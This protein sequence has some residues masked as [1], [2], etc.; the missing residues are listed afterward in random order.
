MTLQKKS[1]KPSPICR[2]C[3]ITIFLYTLSFSITTHAELKIDS[4]YPTLGQMGQNLE[5]EIKG[6]GFDENTRVSMF[7]DSSNERMLVGSVDT[8][9]IDQTNDVFVSGSYAY[10]VGYP[11]MFRVIDVSNSSNPEIIGSVD[12]NGHGYGVFVSGSYA[13]VACSPNSLQIV[14]ISNTS[15][16][17]I[18]GSLDLPGETTPGCVYAQSVFVSGSYAYV[19]D[20]DYGLQVID[21]SNPSSPEVIGSVVSTGIAY[22]V[23]VSG[24]YAYLAETGG[25]LTVVDISDPSNPDSLGSVSTYYTPKDVFI[26]GSYAYLANEKGLEVVDISDP[27]NPQIVGSADTPAMARGVFI[28]GSYAYLA[29]HNSGLQIIDISKPSDPQVFGAV[30]TPYQAKKVFVSWNY[31]YVADLLGGLQIIDISNPSKLQSIGSAET[32][33]AARGVFISDTYAYVADWGSFKII[34]ISNPSNPEVIKSMEMGAYRVLIADNYAYVVGYASGIRV[35]DISDPSNPQIMSLIDLPGALGIFISGNY[36]YVADYYNGLQVVDISDP[37]T[38]RVIGTTETPVSGRSVTVSGI[39]AY[40]SYKPSLKDSGLQVINISDPSN[41]QVIGSVDILS[42]EHQ[43]YTFQDVDVSGN[44]VYLAGSASGLHCIDVSNPSNPYLVK[45]LDTPDSAFGVYISGNYAYVA[46]GM[47]GLQA[48]DISFPSIS[49]IIGAVDTPCIAT[50]IFVS[51]NQAFIADGCRSGLVI[52][53]LP[54]EITSIAVNSYTSL[55]VTL[56]SP[57]LAGIYT[58]RVFNETESSELFGAVSFTDDPTTLNSKAVIVAGGGPLASGGTMWE[59]TKLN[60]N[61]AYDALILQGYQHDSICYISEETLN[62]YVDNSSPETFMDDLSY[63]INTWAVDASRLLIYLVDHGGEDEFILYE[64]N[65]TTI[66]LNAQDLDEWLDTLQETMTGPVTFIYD[67]CQSGSFI[68]RLRP[69]DG[70]DRIVITGS[71]YEPSY[72]LEDGK[73]SFSYQFWDKT[74]FNRGNL[75]DAFSYA[76]ESMQSYQSALVE[77]DWDLEGNNNESE[78][79]RIADDMTIQRGGY[80]YIGV[81]PYISSVSDPQVLSS[82]TSAT[83]QANGVID[84]ESVHALIIPPDVNPE[85]SD[86][87]ITDLPTIELTVPDGDYIYEGTYNGFDTEGTYVVVVKSKSTRELYSYVNNSMTIHNIY[88][89]PM[90]TAVTKTSGI[91]KSKP[92]KYEGDSNHNQASVIVINDYAPQVHNFHSVG[93]N[94]WV[95][96]Y[97]IAGEI[98][99]IKASNVSVFC[100]PIIEL[101]DT[102]GATLLAGPVNNGGRWE[103]ESLEW[104]CQENGIY[105]VRITNANS[106]FGENVKYDLK[107][108]HPVAGLPGWLTGIVINSLGQGIGDAVI[109]SDACNTTTMTLDNGVYMIVLPSGTHTVSVNVTGYDPQNQEGVEVLVEEYTHQDFILFS[110]VDSD[111]DGLTDDIEAILGTDHDD[112]DTDDDGILDGDEDANHNGV[113]DSNE[114]DPTMT[115]TDGDGIQDGTELGYTIEHKDADTDIEVFQPDLDPSTTT[116]PLRADTDGDGMSDGEE[117]INYNGRVDEGESD[118][119]E[120]EFPWEIFYPAFIK[121]K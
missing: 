27:V 116:N 23:F 58:L 103:N 107:V 62:E 68:S 12:T 32:S 64:N 73:G 16:P 71:S 105:Y 52:V 36:A 35:L 18:I 61:K 54:V 46:D 24:N 91:V 95:K 75:G 2:F 86:I 115:D 6:S 43:Y 26:S 84:S 40:M 119:N 109:K 5:V 49:K 121:N 9:G 76:Q 29:S 17:T 108:Y 37:S 33:M 20:F 15:S 63:R 38:P 100:D 79:I 42:D 55:S 74:V 97:G 93:D 96:F 25:R 7:L 48:I 113:V 101:F 50:D 45:T 88:S 11:N 59:E 65:E 31:A 69:P 118:P 51:G 47:S 112:A 94:D 8:P 99:K 14:D 110:N 111:D 89:P 72:F 70:K 77:A 1:R 13:Y 44:Y 34:D 66:T 60:T 82:E 21:V 39:Y 117:D 3:V 106:N 81:H 28:S 120:E 53:P 87:P 85:T 80:S 10:E 22:D 90:Y 92:D 114:T 83:I 104:S 78:D 56:P 19:A 67:A 41:P 30:D 98:Y 102:N 4:V 57:I